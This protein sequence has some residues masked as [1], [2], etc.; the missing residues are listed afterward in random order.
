MRFFLPSILVSLPLAALATVEGD[1]GGPTSTSYGTI[2]TTITHTVAR[3]TAYLTSTIPSSTPSPTTSK[4]TSTTSTTFISSA[5]TTSTTSTD[6]T[7]L[8]TTV[9]LSSAPVYSAPLPVQSFNATTGVPYPVFSG[10]SVVLPSIVTGNIGTGSAAIPGPGPTGQQPFTPFQGKASRLSGSGGLV[11]A[12]VAI[13]VG[14]IEM[15]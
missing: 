2:T 12:L 10:S 8:P 15:Q 1:D 4:T 9:V 14:V 6:S 5:S 11:A 13:V 3:Y 7:T